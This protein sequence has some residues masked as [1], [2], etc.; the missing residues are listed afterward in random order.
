MLGPTNKVMG[1][2]NVVLADI[3]HVNDDGSFTLTSGVLDRDPIR[4]GTGERVSD[5]SAYG[6]N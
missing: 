6:T 2:V 4:Q 5:V 3:D 1:Q